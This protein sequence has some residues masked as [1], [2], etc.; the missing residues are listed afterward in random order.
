MCAQTAARYAAQLAHRQYDTVDPDNR[1]VAAELERRWNVALEKERELEAKVERE[2]LHKQPQPPNPDELRSL[3]ADLKLVWDSPETDSRLKKRIIRTLV[4]EIVVDIDVDQSEV[5][6]VVHWMGDAHSELRVPRRRRG[7]SGAHTS[8]DVVEAIRNL[9]LICRDK[10]IAGYL[11]R[12]GLL[13]ARGNRWSSM[14]ITSLRNKRGIAVYTPEQQQLDGWM[15]LTQ[16]AEYLG[17]SSKT[18]RRAVEQ[19]DLKA[20][21]PLHDGPW[22][23][24]R[25]NLDNPGFREPFENRVSGKAPPAGPDSRQLDLTISTTYRG[26]AL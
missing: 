14:A 6:L 20:L 12:N 1:L 17:V 22:V 21:H 16:A 13:T 15:N 25:A 23:I 5:V 3:A 4:E 24:N 9:A 19:G 26:E 11:N 18:V 8:A 7:Q 2:Q 10:E